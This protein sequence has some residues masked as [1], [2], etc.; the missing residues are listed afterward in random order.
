MSSNLPRVTQK[1]FAENAGENIGQFGSA[2]SG[3]ANRT[4]D[5]E[6][7]QALPAWGKGWAGAVISERDYP[8]LEE[9]TG[10]QKVASQQIAY[11]LQKGI[12][13]WDE[14]T[15]YFANTSF[16][17]VNGVVYQSLTDNN[18]GNNPTTDTTNWRTWKPLEGTYANIDLSN[19]SENGNAHFANPDLSNLS[20][21]GLDKI[22]QSKALETGNVSS[23]K[24]VYA[25][26][27]K[28]AHSTFDKSKFEIVGNPVITDDGIASGFQPHNATRITLNDTFN[29]ANKN[30]NFTFGGKLNGLPDQDLSANAPLLD[31]RDSVNNKWILVFQLK[32]GDIQMSNSHHGGTSIY[33]Q[34][35]T[36]DDLNGDFKADLIVNNENIILNFYQNG[37]KK[38]IQ[39]AY[40]NKLEN[41]KIRFAYGLEN[42][43]PG[44]YDL[45]K[46]SLTISGI[47]VFSGS[48]TSI[49]TIKP[50][51]YTV[52]G[53]PTISAD[54][55]ASGFSTSNYLTS[56][57]PNLGNNFEIITPIVN[58]TNVEGNQCI[59][60]VDEL[61]LGISK[62][63][64][65]LW[66]YK[67][68]KNDYSV[69]TGKQALTPNI[70]YI[71]KVTETFDG[72]NYNTTLFSSTDNG[73]SWQKEGNWLNPN[74]AYF[75]NGLLYIGRRSDPTYSFVLNGNA[76]LNTGKVFINGNLIYQ[77]C[78]KIPYTLSKT[79]SKIVDAAYRDRIQDMYEQYGY[80][81]Y[82]TI[83]EGNQDFT[84]PMGELYGFY[85][86]Y[87]NSINQL[88]DQRF[89]E[90]LD[91]V[92]P[93]GRPVPEVNNYLAA[94]EVW[95][96]GAIVNIAD[97][98]LLYQKYGTKYGGDGVTTFGLIDARNKALFWGS[99]DGSVKYIGPG[100]P[101]IRGAFTFTGDSVARPIN[102]AAREAFYLVQNT[103]RS[104][105]LENTGDNDLLKILEFAFN[106]SQY[107]PIYQDAL[108]GFVIPNS[109]Q[110]RFK[111]RYK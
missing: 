24:D 110:V 21:I 50:D 12:P 44:S 37:N 8:P 70:S 77:P 68:N 58:F 11:L 26:V 53:T 78:L 6:T 111:T 54:G 63:Y 104:P 38:T 48:V 101:N 71:F 7:I 65:V 14:G 81:P 19:L 59:L 85:E 33:S 18:T 108:S 22:N 93:I 109:F 43:F 27:L 89:Q 40:P 60:E 3:T 96:E 67:A 79:G 2:L 107:N 41:T 102:G 87:K 106:A 32:N 94:N 105:I 49:D 39:C 99:P 61:F 55:I 72:A 36:P 45:K 10:V 46:C 91:L 86:K 47:P 25:D 97:Y 15:T 84:L 17:Q 52:V 23:D 20:D 30:F 69:Y 34:A 51:D 4:G 73:F 95:L 75:N 16:C 100:L 9:M 74:P 90:L 5:I 64:P 76:D 98:P 28:Y 103:E 31:I 88:S 82:Y 92:Y 29:F 56:Q 1:I 80:A 62:G 35:I 42:A 66:R 13:E 57:M 83:D